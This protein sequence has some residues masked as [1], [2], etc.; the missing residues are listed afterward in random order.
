MKKKINIRGGSL[1]TDLPHVDAIATG[2][3]KLLSNGNLTVCKSPKPNVIHY[4]KGS[5]WR[6]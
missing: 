6:T 1:L 3:A 4:L 2:G 5:V